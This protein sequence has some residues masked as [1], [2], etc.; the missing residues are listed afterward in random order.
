MERRNFMRGAGL[1]GILAAGVAPSVVM[2]QQNVRWR[3][4]CAYPRSTDVAFGA[5]ET[6]AANLRKLTSGRFEI[7]VFAGGEIVPPFSVFDAVQQGTVEAG[8]AMPYYF[9][10]KNEAF[11][12]DCIIP[13][14]MN[15]R[16]MTAWMYD[17]GGWQ[18]FRELYARYDVVNFP[19][20]N[21][22]TQ[23]GGWYRKEIRSLEDLKG[24]KMRIGNMG[25]QILAR[26][27]GLPQA[28]PGGEIY[29]AL[30][31][32]TIDAVEWTHPYDDYKMGFHRIAPYGYYP[33]WWEGGGQNT[34]FVNRK[35][36]EALSPEYQAALASAASDVHVRLSSQFDAR[37]PESLRKLL[38]EGAKIRRMPKD[39]MDAAYKASQE[40]F[41]ELSAR[42]EDWRRIYP[43]YEK[44]M[45][46]AYAWFRLS[47][48]SY[49]QY[50]AS[51]TG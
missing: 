1:V 42:N 9:I 33:A 20:G 25:G 21:T 7:Q 48:I 41:A 43:I 18:I 45:K 29:Q 50:M 14:G 49:D 11:A 31:K 23:W 8:H 17:G 26:L 37:N 28:I 5:G 40:Y 38:A 34:L 32:G 36:Y 47:E 6:L 39:V 12:L 19:F 3:L 2:A 4:V 35:A 10:G 30:E 44:F 27:G 22:G 24:L 16:M 13:F 15:S 51:V 46:D